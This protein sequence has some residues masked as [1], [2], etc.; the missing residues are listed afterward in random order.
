MAGAFH[1]VSGADH[2][3][4]LLPSVVACARPVEGRLESGV[5]RAA[6][7]GAQW[8]TGH[9]LG[10]GCAGAL[11]VCLKKMFAAKVMSASVYLE[12]ITGITL[13]VIGLSGL[14]SSG[15]NHDHHDLL[16][17]QKTSAVVARRRGSPL[18]ESRPSLT[19]LDDEESVHVHGHPHDGSGASIYMGV[20]HGFTGTG[21]LVGV[22][23]SS[24]TSW[25]S[26]A[27]LLHSL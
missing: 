23:V 19:F 6:K 2:I 9:S 27:R 13:L 24:L 22:V 18:D 10:A 5:Y 8:G 12:P 3:A 7:I 14:R 1:A 4:A 11:A 25:L 16:L 21:H 20:L 15:T 26:L 17:Q